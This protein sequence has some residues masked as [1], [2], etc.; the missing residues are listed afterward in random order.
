MMIKLYKGIM[1]IFFGKCMFCWNCVVVFN[2]DGIRMVGIFLSD[3]VSFK[4]FVDEL[5]V[6]VCVV[7]L[8]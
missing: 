2:W 3:G 1:N 8:L 4:G 6:Y 7:R 5:V